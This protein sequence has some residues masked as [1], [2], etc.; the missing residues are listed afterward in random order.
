MTDNEQMTAKNKLIEFIHSLTDEECLIID[1]FLKQN[2]TA[3][4]VIRE[5]MSKSATSLSFF[6]L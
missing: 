3:T 5:K 4:N 6:V 2:N 1:S